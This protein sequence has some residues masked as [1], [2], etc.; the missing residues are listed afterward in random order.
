MLNIKTIFYNLF[1]VKENLM[2]NEEL[3]EV[4]K[5]LVNNKEWIMKLPTT[6]KRKKDLKKTGIK[7]R[8]CL[9]SFYN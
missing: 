9:N 7:F 1:R 3:K 8:I 6:K 4:E 2:S 5:I